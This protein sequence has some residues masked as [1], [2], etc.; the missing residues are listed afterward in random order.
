MHSQRVIV[1]L[2]LG[3]L[4][5]IFQD[6]SLTFMMAYELFIQFVCPSQI[7]AFENLT[8]TNIGRRAISGLKEL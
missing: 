5:I 4:G 1:L 2:L 3:N 6:G 8:T 7:P